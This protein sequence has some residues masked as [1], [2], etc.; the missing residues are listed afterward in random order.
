[1]S[2]RSP[3][4]GQRPGTRAHPPRTQRL[5]PPD[6][7]PRVNVS[8]EEA[9]DAAAEMPDLSDTERAVLLY[10]AANPTATQVEIGAAAGISDRQVRNVQ[11]SQAYLAA[12]ERLAVQA[13]RRALAMLRHG[14][15]PAARKLLRIIGSPYADHVTVSAI[16]ALFEVTN[17][18][19]LEVTG[20]NGVPL[21]PEM[22]DEERLAA[23]QQLLASVEQ[24]RAAA[25]A[26]Q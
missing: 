21:V 18:K 1:M 22:T 2:G 25:E 23:I 11:R 12:A 13:Q 24:R 26:A 3:K 10:V 16:R 4:R 6:D 20:A 9:A 14:M 7:A 17:A 5:L 8:T 19:R 15:E